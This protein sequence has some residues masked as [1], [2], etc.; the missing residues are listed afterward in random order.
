MEKVK[1]YNEDGEE[2]EEEEQV[3]ALPP[4][5]QRIKWKKGEYLGSGQYSRV[6]KG[7]NLRNGR[8][9]AVKQV[10]QANSRVQQSLEAEISLLS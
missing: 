10:S 3:A 9:M 5:K 2:E 7:L 8:L 6:Y 1:R 4:P